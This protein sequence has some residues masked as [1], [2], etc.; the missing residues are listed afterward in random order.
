MDVVIFL[1]GLI[2]ILIGVY[3]IIVSFIPVLGIIWCFIPAII[4]IVIGAVAGS[5]GGVVLNLIA[6]FIM[7]IWNLIVWIFIV[8]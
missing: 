8:K 2:S 1:L 3:C 6:I 5:V 4:G 7:I